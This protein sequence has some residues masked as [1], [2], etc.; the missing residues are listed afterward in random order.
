M[1]KKVFISIAILCTV[2]FIQCTSETIIQDMNNPTLKAGTGGDGGGDHTETEGNNLS[3]PVITTDG[4]VIAPIAETNFNYIYEGGYDGL[5]AD[6]IL[7]IEANGDW[8]AQKVEGNIWQAQYLNSSNVNV[9]FIDWGD[10]IEAVNPIANSSFRIELTLY[11]E[12]APM[13]AYT[14]AVLANPSSTDEIQGTNKVQY[15]GN[16]ATVASPLPL[17]LIQYLEEGAE[18]VWSESNGKWEG[19]GVGSPD[20]DIRFASELNVGGKYIYGAYM[21]GWEPKTEGKYRITFYV[22]STSSIH[23]E[24]AYIGNYSGNDNLPTDP[25]NNVSEAIV[26]GAK[27]ISYTDVTV[28]SSGGRGGGN[29]GGNGGGRPTR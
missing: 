13:N 29:G 9:T 23:L 18:P 6:E 5:T 28:V 4:F 16:Y 2:F 15:D 12:T 27:N 26:D 24:G 1:I 8:Y 11:V 3:F 20:A 22:P 19:D 14:M 21:S 7:Y 25:A 10:A 17:L